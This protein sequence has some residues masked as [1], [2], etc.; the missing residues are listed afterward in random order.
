MAHVRDSHARDALLLKRVLHVQKIQIL[1]MS[2]LACV[3]KAAGR[4]V[5]SALKQH[6]QGT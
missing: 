6:C 4:A 5:M 2:P 3:Y 1:R